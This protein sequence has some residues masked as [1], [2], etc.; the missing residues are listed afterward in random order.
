M[1]RDKKSVPSPYQDKNEPILTEQGYGRFT[2]Q[3]VTNLRSFRDE[4]LIGILTNVLLQSEISQDDISLLKSSFDGNP[5]LFD[6][7][8]KVF[9]PTKEESSIANN[10]RWSDKKF[11]DMSAEDAKINLLARQGSIRFVDTG[12]QRL[13]NIV[14]GNSGE[15]LP[16]EVDIGLVRDYKDVDAEEVKYNAVLFQDSMMFLAPRIT[17]INSLATMKEETPEEQKARL[18]KD[19]TK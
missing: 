13:E 9:R 5:A 1:D 6:T 7:V 8:C 19:G 15:P 3:E 16:T 17:L 11:V 10:T 12:L 18:K 4:R 2:K 14:K